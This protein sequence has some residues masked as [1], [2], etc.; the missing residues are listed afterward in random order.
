MAADEVGVIE[1]SGGTGVF[2]GAGGLVGDGI[3]ANV[4]AATVSA[5]IKVG[6]ATVHAA[7]NITM[8]GMN[9]R[10][11]ISRS[12]NKYNLPLVLSISN[13][14]YHYSIVT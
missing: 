10:F 4:N 3:A 7:R 9:A 12:L 6:C 8:K 11:M 1:G 13:P 5:G 14:R 2:G